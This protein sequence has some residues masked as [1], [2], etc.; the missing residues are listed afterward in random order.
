MV[1]TPCHQVEMLVD[2]SLIR[3]VCFFFFALIG[4]GLRW[5][6]DR[7]GPPSVLAVDVTIG[8]SDCL[9]RP[10]KSLCLVGVSSSLI[11]RRPP[12]A[13]FLSVITL[14]LRE[15]CGRLGLEVRGSG[16]VVGG[17]CFLISACQR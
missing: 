4:Q 3:D 15:S 8:T 14:S 16:V 5:P 6:A 9:L 2:T 10:G 7:P 1:G 12:V 17:G 13:V 11:R